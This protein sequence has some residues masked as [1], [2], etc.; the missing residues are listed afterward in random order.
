MDDQSE[1]VNVC[2]PCQ[3]G[4]EPNPALWHIAV[5]AE[6]SRKLGKLGKMQTGEP[7]LITK[8]GKMDVPG[9]WSDYCIWVY[10]VPCVRADDARSLYTHGE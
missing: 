1:T 3:R 2:V 5:H 7:F 10:Q 9:D 4:K 6:I 8:D